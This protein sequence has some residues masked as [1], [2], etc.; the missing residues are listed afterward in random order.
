MFVPAVKAIWAH[1]EGH[2]SPL[3]RKQA[4]RSGCIVSVRGKA[5]GKDMY[6]GLHRGPIPYQQHWAWTS[7]TTTAW[8]AIGNYVCPK[9]DLEKAEGKKS[10][11]FGN[12]VLVCLYGKLPL[13]WR[14]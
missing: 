3:A 6:L 4:T 8:Q 2:K 5:Q 12:G 10:S 7:P 13:E 11:L 14:G 9:K 1:R